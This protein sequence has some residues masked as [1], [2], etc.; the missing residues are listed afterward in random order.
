MT[1]DVKKALF[2]ETLKLSLW[3]RTNAAIRHGI[4]D[5]QTLTSLGDGSDGTIA[6]SGQAQAGTPNP[7]GES[8]GTGA[9]TGQPGATQ[10]VSGVVRATVLALGALASAGTGAAAVKYLAPTI[11]TKTIERGSLLQYLEDEGHHRYGPD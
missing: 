3:H 6:T 8:T 10:G 11:V 1:A 2:T 9:P 7:S 4:P 5:R